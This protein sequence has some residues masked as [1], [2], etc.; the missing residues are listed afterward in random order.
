[1]KGHHQIHFSI[2][3]FHLALEICVFPIFDNFCVRTKNLNQNFSFTINLIEGVTNNPQWEIWT[4]TSNS[5]VKIMLNSILIIS[6]H[7][8]CYKDF[9]QEQ[10]YSP[11]VQFSLSLMYSMSFS[12]HLSFLILALSSSSEC[13][14]LVHLD[15]FLSHRVFFS[16][17]F[18]MNGD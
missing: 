14:V 3:F 5:C 2:K 16:H 6:Y 13:V 18:I 9:F 8:L 1:M 11:F 7:G 10:R 12:L 4:R 17:F 15:N